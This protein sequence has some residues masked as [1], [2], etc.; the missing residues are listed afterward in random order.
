M[1]LDPSLKKDKLKVAI[2]GTGFGSL[3]HFPA[4]YQHASFDPVIIV[5]QNEEKTKRIAEELGLDWSVN[6]KEVIDD[7]NID[8]ISIVTPPKMHREI[9]ESAFNS[10]KHVICEKPMGINLT[11]AKILRDIAEESPQIHICNYE[12]RYL[13]SRA[14]F[15][16]LLKTGYIGDIYS[17]AIKINSNSRI[18]PRTQGYNWWSERA[19][20]GGVLNS[21]GS[22]YIDFILQIFGHIKGVYGRRFTHITKRL[23]KSTGRMRNT[24]ADDAISIMIEVE[25]VMCTIQISTVSTHGNG[26]TIEAKGS[27]GSICIK[28]DQQLYGAILGENQDLTP[29]AIPTIYQLI[30]QKND[31]IL[32]PSFKRLLDNF[33]A[34]VNSGIAH[35]PNFGDAYEVQK[36]IDAINQSHQK[37]KYI[38]IK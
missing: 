35:S 24:S 1:L 10:G 28:E 21:L 26:T 18:N 37:K 38:P 33:V 29:L 4:F 5:G 22:H 9:A 19:A 31:H 13:P 27:K 3:V 23:N 25:K 12:F 7:P 8:V 6:W 34:G 20:G 2:I 11:E 14:Y 16:E 36:I 17:L 32:I 30:R 15:V